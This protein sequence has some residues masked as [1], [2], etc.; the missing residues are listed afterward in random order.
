VGAGFGNI[1][2][3]QPR[4]RSRS[5]T[6][7]SEPAQILYSTLECLFFNPFKTVASKELL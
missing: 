4:Q 6:P 5:E 2:Y 1:F 3:A 7:D